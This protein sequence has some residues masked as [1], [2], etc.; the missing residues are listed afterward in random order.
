[1]SKFES[2][3][4]MDLILKPIHSIYFKEGVIRTFDVDEKTI[5]LF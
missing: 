4:Y 2:D 1:M 5:Q 3:G